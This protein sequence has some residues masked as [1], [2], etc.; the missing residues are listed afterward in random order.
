MGGVNLDYMIIFEARAEYITKIE[1]IVP[2]SRPPKWKDSL[3]ITEHWVNRY[4]QSDSCFRC[5]S[6]WLVVILYS[7]LRP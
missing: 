5:P 4:L 2:A 7:L 6:I 1:Q 3:R